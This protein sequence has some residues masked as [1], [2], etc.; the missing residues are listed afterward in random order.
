MSVEKPSEREQ[1]ASEHGA[2]QGQRAAGRASESAA[3][4][5]GDH[6]AERPDHA[7]SSESAPPCDGCG[8]S[9][10]RLVEVTN[11]DGELAICER[12]E[13]QLRA[14]VVRELDRFP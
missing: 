8:A 1:P 6:T 3:D 2:Q 12:C 11:P 7:A 4:Q 10:D 14:A 5:A 13:E 9:A